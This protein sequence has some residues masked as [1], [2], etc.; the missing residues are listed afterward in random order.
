MELKKGREPP[1]L[2]G[3]FRE[4]IGRPPEGRRTVRYERAANDR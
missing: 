3:N 1:T 4:V 2:Q